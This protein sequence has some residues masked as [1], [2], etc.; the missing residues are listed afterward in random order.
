MCQHPGCESRTRP[1]SE[2]HLKSG[3]SKCIICGTVT[4]DASMHIVSHFCILYC[5]VS[6]LSQNSTK[7]F[8]TH[9]RN[10]LAGLVCQSKKCDTVL[11]VGG[12]IFLRGQT[13]PVSLRFILVCP[14][15][16]VPVKSRS[17]IL[18]NEFNIVF[19]VCMYV[20]LKI[21][22]HGS[23]MER[24]MI[25]PALNKRVLWI[26]GRVGYF[27]SRCRS[28]RKSATSTPLRKNFSFFD[29]RVACMHFGSL[30]RTNELWS[31]IVVY[32][33]SRAFVFFLRI[34]SWGSWYQL[35]IVLLQE[36]EIFYQRSFS[37]LSLGSNAFIV[38]SF[39]KSWNRT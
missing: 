4:A 18:S 35:P 33:I 30:K 10:M 24:K 34:F 17:V 13:E 28:C 23:S 36:G 5:F 14:F 38:P 6:L 31:R 29:R 3:A 12:R 21:A 11:L 20:Y 37:K 8:R 9:P 7:L 32:H 19:Y 15:G 25:F 16:V 1:V 2:S 27:P 22:S 26:T 39:G